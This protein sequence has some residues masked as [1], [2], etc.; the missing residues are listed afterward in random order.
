[1]QRRV[2]R[3][4]EVWG[5][6]TE[7]SKATGSAPFAEIQAMAESA[8]TQGIFR[9]L[10]Q[11]FV[12]AALRALAEATMEYMRQNPKGAE[13]YRTFGFEVLWSGIARKR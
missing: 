1:V 6:L 8:V 13:T 10:P 5:G 11:Q 7:E 2:L 12:L 3:Q 9:D 4:I